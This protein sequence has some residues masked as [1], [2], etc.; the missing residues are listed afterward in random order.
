LFY[1]IEDCR[2]VRCSH[3][4]VCLL[5]KNNGEPICYPRKHCN[6][7][8]NPEPVCGT[9]GVNYPNICAMRLSRD[10]RGRS[11]DLAHKGSCGMTLK[12]NFISIFLFFNI[13]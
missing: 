12:E 3:D 11:P 2:N 7:T 1:I 4:K 6:P 5:V 8:L 13:Y 9:N 10:R